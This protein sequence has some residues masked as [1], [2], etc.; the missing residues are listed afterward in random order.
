MAIVV[1]THSVLDSTTRLAL[2]VNTNHHLVLWQIIYQEVLHSVL[3]LGRGLY[4]HP[5]LLEAL[6]IYTKTI[7]TPSL[8][9]ENMVSKIYL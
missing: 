9:V 1:L 3:L 5:P 7:K 8:F 2:R 6:A 4:Y